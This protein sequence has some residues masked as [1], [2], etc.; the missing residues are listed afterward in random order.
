MEV[1]M[2]FATAV[3]ALTALLVPSPAS[4]VEVVGAGDIASR[5]SGDTRTSALI[6]ALDPARVLTFGDN[7]YPDGTLAQFN[8]FY[9]PT[10]GRF[11]SITKPSP[12]NHD[13]HTGGAAGYEAYFGSAF[14]AGRLVSYERLV[15][16]WDIYQLDT[17]RKLSSQIGA[18]DN[19]LASN[20]DRCELVYGHHPRFSSG[21]H[22]D[23]PS[24]QAL[25]STLVANDVDLYLVGHDHNYERFAEMDASG[26][27]VT[28]GTRQVVVGT[29]GVATRPFGTASIG[30]T[31]KKLTG[32]SNWGVLDLELVSGSYSAQFRRA[33]GGTG[34]V[35]DSFS[36]DCD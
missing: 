32:N 15:A 9:D 1:P 6:L 21:K 24:K 28:N 12:G 18:L 23:D 4:G 26:D 5:G 22:G 11:R 2:R 36:G 14:P 35:A 8:N 7:A 34:T 33:T 20:P 13:W 29:G 30:A 25:W 31:Q 17:E 10:W 19:R 3:I 16:G 27:A